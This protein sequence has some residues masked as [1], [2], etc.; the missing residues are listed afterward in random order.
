MAK[1]SGPIGFG[2]MTKTAGV[3]KE[4]ITEYLYTGDVIRNTRGVQSTDQVND[5]VTVSNSI[6][7]VADPFATEN[8]HEM[9]YV[10]FMGTKWKITNVDIKYPRLILTMGGIYNGK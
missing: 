10:E 9:R 3:S 5:N 6:S 7:I 1:F 8:F 4:I 2:K